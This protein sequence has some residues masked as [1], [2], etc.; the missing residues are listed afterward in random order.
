MFT[1]TI[2][3]P[4]EVSLENIIEAGWLCL[5]LLFQEKRWAHM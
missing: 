4:R 5:K 2:E 1:G 3:T